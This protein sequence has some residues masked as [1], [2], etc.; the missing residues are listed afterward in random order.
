MAYHE[1]R[2]Y[3]TTDKIKV[4]GCSPEYGNPS[5]HS[6]FA[7]AM[8]TFVF[9]DVF[10]AQEDKSRPRT[11]A[12]KLCRG[13]WFII[14]VSLTFLICFAR[15]YVGVHTLNQIVY[16]LSWGLWLAFY[17]HFCLRENVMRHIDTL[18]QKNEF[19]IQMCKSILVSTILAI[20]VFMSQ[21]ATFLIVD[22]IFQTDPLWLKRL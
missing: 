8:D 19:H 22:S 9:L 4:Y 3:M 12:W 10:Y 18:T 2:P 11:V 14:S 7:G 1:P 6:I 16:G 5:G 15:F 20:V 21:V 13:F 17:F